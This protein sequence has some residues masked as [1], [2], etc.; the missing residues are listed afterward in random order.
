M[1]RMNIII[2][3]I[4]QWRSRSAIRNDPATRNNGAM[5][6][7]P[8][9]KI[10]ISTQDSERG[11]EEFMAF[12]KEAT[13]LVMNHFEQTEYIRH[14]ALVR[15]IN[16]LLYYTFAILKDDYFLGDHI[17]KQSITRIDDYIFS[18]YRKHPD[19]SGNLKKMITLACSNRFSDSPRENLLSYF[20]FIEETGFEL[21]L[22]LEDFY[23]LLETSQ[24]KKGSV[25]KNTILSK[26]YKKEQMLK[27]GKTG[28]L[29]P[30]IQTLVSEE[31][32][33][34]INPAQA[35][36]K[37]LEELLKKDAQKRS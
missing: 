4:N 30:T 36:R 1:S 25:R 6:V 19:L 29:Q 28:D 37:I 31:M 32:S 5:L 10:N 27:S 24:K 2:K 23:T 16:F 7:K 20:V 18:Q 3:L 15:E 12:E 22:L 26:S 8:K 21:I 34:L 9:V 17:L 11:A 35:Q 14:R 33:E 13:R